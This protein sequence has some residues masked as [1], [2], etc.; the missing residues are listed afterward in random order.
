MQDDQT[1]LIDLIQAARNGDPD[2]LVTWCLPHIHAVLRRRVDR[3]D[4]DDLAQDTIYRM[5]QRIGQVSGNGQKFKAWLVRLA[6]NIASDHWRREYRKATQALPAFTEDI[7]SCRDDNTPEAI[8]MR[9]E[10]SERLQRALSSLSSNHRNVI[11]LHYGQGLKTDEVAELTGMP[12]GTVRRLLSEARERLRE[13]L[14]D[15]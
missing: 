9:Q 6:H 2:A 11:V 1:K 12:P 10:L 5:L 7:K 15:D 4:V 14:T 3:Q 8:M 13:M